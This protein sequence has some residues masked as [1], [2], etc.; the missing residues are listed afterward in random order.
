MGAVG[1]VWGPLRWSGVGVCWGWYWGLLGLGLVSKGDY[2]AV[3]SV[4]MEVR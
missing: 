3:R 4:E 2:G 1:L